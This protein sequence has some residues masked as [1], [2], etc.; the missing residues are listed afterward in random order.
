MREFIDDERGYLRWINDH[1][2][3]FVVNSHR[4]PPPDYIVLHNANCGSISSPKI[5]NYTTHAYVKYCSDD[6]SELHAWARS[7]VGGQLHSCGLC[8][9]Q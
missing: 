8:K 2:Q 9:P 5:K 4:A 6:P 1:S 3:G 7:A